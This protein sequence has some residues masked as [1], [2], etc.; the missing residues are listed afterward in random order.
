MRDGGAQSKTVHRDKSGA[1]VD[2][3]AGM[4]SEKDRLR[5]ANEAQLKMWK[6]GSKQVADKEEYKRALEEAKDQPFA[7]YEMDAAAERELKFRERF[8]DPMK[9]IKS[10]TI[11][12]RFN[13]Q[14]YRVLTTA[15]GHRYLLSRC[16]F[17]GTVN[18]FD[19]EPGHRWDGV[20]RGN[21]YEQKWFDRANAQKD[22]EDF[23][24]KWAAEDM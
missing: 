19:V 16:K 7:R 8:G 11:R 14:T 20:D 21:K 4:L 6:G 5:Q 18:R 10:G 13:D 22:T 12:S 23:H 15:N 9:L 3:K 1:I 24:R 17:T 2:L